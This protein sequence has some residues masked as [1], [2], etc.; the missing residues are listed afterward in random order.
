M[1]IIYCYTNKING[2]KY[3]GQ[4]L[5]PELRK[6]QHKSN[7]FNE[8]SP[9]YNSIIH[10]AFRKYGYENFQYTIL[11]YDIDCLQLLNT[12]EQ[13]YIKKYDTMQPNGYNILQGGSNASKPKDQ[14][15]KKKLIWGQ[16]KMTEE[17]I[18]ELRKAYQ[19]HQSPTDIYNE[20]YAERLHYNSFLNIWTGKRYGLIMPE[21]FQDKG[22]HTKLNEQIV[23]QIKIDRQNTGMSYQNLAKKYNVSKSC[24]ADIIKQRTWKQVQ[25]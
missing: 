7:A 18:I 24:I 20:K 19:N 4:T 22:R 25:I 5:N 9:E 6:K 2:K 11:C 15:Y 8:K 21:V 13:Y 3:I 17:Q 12:L 23:R 14:E 1:G 10:R 16:A